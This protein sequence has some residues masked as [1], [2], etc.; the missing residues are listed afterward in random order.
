MPTNPRTKLK[1]LWMN[2][3]KKV[4]A[5]EVGQVLVQ[6]RLSNGPDSMT[7]RDMVE[8]TTGTEATRTAEAT[9]V[10][11]EEEAAAV[12]VTTGL[13]ADALI[14]DMEEVE[15]TVVDGEVE[16]TM[17][18]EI[19]V[20][21]EEEVGMVVEVM[22]AVEEEDI[23]NI[24]RPTASSSHH[25]NR[26]SASNKTMVSN[27]TASC[28]SPAASR[29]VSHSSTNNNRCSN[30]SP[31]SMDPL[32]ISTTATTRATKLPQVS[33]RLPTHSL[34]NNSSS[35]NNSM[36]KPHSKP[37]NKALTRIIKVTTLGTSSKQDMGVMV[38]ALAISR[39][40]A[41]VL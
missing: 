25:S 39:L 35:S 23:V 5:T 19:I 27:N 37:S 16:D 11:E 32:T 10:E 33:N 4:A 7:G 36:A 18:D 6:N 21:E 20:V 2:T 12:E 15:V 3:S 26:G 28:H 8:A 29:I 30:S 13:V 31:N 40:E 9:G 34:N 41:N 38:V 22:A 1:L 17:T 24:S 14:M